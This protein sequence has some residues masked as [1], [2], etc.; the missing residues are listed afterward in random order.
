MLDL[1]TGRTVAISPGPQNLVF[2][3]D[4][5]DASHLVTTQDQEREEPIVV[6][7]WWAASRT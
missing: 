7:I 2:H 3:P 1:T 6:R 5:H 4:K